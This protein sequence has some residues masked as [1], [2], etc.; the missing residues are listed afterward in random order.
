MEAASSYRYERKFSVGGMI[1]EEIVALIKLHP[2]VFFEIYSAR[3]VNNLY[4]DTA[5]L[6]NYFDNIDGQ[7]DRQKV[8][9]RWY[10]DLFGWIEKPV[11]EIKIKK[12][13]LGTKERLLLPQF[14]FDD[15]FQWNVIGNVF[16][17]SAI[18]ARWRELLLDLEPALVNRYRRRYF[19]SVNHAFRITVDTDMTYFQVNPNC[20][21]FLHNAKDRAGIIVEIKYDAAAEK[22]IYALMADLPFRLTKSSKYVVGKDRLCGV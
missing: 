21:S 10:G 15:S 8:R 14:Q 20:N 3:F 4:L 7:R 18:P 22:D 19:E 5:R 13:F 2:A 1:P 9:V 6:R 17:A 12:A 11:L 16:K